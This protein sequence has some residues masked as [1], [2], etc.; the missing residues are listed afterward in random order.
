M[1][2]D[3][4]VR[5]NPLLEIVNKFDEDGGSVFIRYDKLVKIIEDESKL[6]SL[7]IKKRDRE[8]LSR[9]VFPPEPNTR[10]FAVDLTRNED[11]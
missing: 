5:G 4:I 2:E 7:P 1:H 3:L 8:F 11:D 10:K 6:R 9:G